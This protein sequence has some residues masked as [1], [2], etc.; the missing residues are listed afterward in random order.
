MRNL[1][2]YAD[3]IPVKVLKGQEANLFYLDTIIESGLRSE[4]RIVKGSK[5]D[6]IIPKKRNEINEIGVEIYARN[7][8]TKNS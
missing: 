3:R 2:W 6:G 8:K 7:S 4:A 5:V 1:I